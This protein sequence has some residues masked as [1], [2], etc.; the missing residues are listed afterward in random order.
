MRPV[1]KAWPILVVTVFF[2]IVIMLVQGYSNA[3]TW[4]YVSNKLPDKIDYL[5][6]F[7]GNPR[8]EIYA[9]QLYKQYFPVWIVSTIKKSKFLRWAN[10]NGVDTNKIVVTEKC[11]STL[12][13]IRYFKN[14]IDS[15]SQSEM[16]S[17]AFVSSPLHMR[18]ILILNYLV[19]RTYTSKIYS[20]PV[21]LEKDGLSQ[22]LIDEWRESKIIRNVVH[23]ELIKILG[24]F[25]SVLPCLGPWINERMLK[26]KGMVYKR[27]DMLKRRV[28]FEK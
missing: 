13:E 6:T 16:L 14:K 3:A 19:N 21:P 26:N 11:E 9:L 15:L 1:S 10:Q 24:G 25:L 17:V 20:L 18:R 4:L 5:C 22:K 12:D 8:R 2:V 27:L 23:M 28:M 7:S